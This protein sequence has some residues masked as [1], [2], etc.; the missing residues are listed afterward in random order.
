VTITQKLVIKN[1]M[2]FLFEVISSRR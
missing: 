2:S 1:I